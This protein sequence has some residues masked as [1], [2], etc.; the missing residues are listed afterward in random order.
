MNGEIFNKMMQDYLIPDNFFFFQYG[1]FEIRDR[2]FFQTCPC[3]SALVSL[4]LGVT[5]VL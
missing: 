2:A 5:L 3:L 4:W 1:D